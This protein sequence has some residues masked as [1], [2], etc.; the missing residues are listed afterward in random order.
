MISDDD[1]IVYGYKRDFESY[2]LFIYLGDNSFFCN[3][4]SSRAEAENYYLYLKAKYLR[5]HDLELQGYKVEHF[6][7]YSINN[8]KDEMDWPEPIDHEEI[9]DWKDNETE[10]EDSEFELDSD[11]L[12]D[13][14]LPSLSQII[15]RNK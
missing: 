6:F 8:G 4:F 11:M 12:T 7:T 5:E 1:V 9:L 13:D 3:S 14:E 2:G 15:K 10:D